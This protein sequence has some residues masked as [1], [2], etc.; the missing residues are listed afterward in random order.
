MKNTGLWS[1]TVYPLTARMVDGGWLQ[2]WKV[3]D[4]RHVFKLKD[5][6]KEQAKDIRLMQEYIN[7]TT[8]KKDTIFLFNN[9]PGW[10]FLLD[11]ENA[12]KYDF[13][14]LALLKRDRLE[15]V[16]MLEKNNPVYIIEDL[17]AW[18]VDEVSDRQR[19][20]E[21]LNYMNKNYFVYAKKEHF[22][23]YKKR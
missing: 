11:R 13:P 6:A 21:V 7:R 8:R 15:L 18:P 3:A 17:N 5:D 1:G 12:T 20:P 16:A 4:G 9:M 14:L 2:L 19:M 23:I 22:L 10:Y